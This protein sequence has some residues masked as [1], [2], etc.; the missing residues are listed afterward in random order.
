MSQGKKL[1]STPS[2][3]P[4]CGAAVPPKALA[5]SACGADERTGW[6]EERTRYD[7]LD[8]PDHA[9]DDDAVPHVEKTS[10]SIVPKGVSFFWWIVGVGLT[11]L[12]VILLGF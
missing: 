10:P 2:E 3:C 1:S 5:C 11:I 6:D 9:F 8:L 7:G 4:I 12:L